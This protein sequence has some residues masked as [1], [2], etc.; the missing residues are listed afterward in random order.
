MPLLFII[1]INNFSR[2]SDLLFTILFADDTSVFIEGTSY[3]KVIDVL[4]Q[5][6]KRV[7][8]WLKANTL[9]INTQKKPH[10][11]M[12]HRTRIKDDCQPI[13]IDGNPI[14]YTKN[15][16]FLGVI[17]DQKLNWSDHILY[18]KNEISK[19]IGIINKTRNLLDKNTVRNLYF[20]FI[21]PYLIYCIEIWG[22]TNGRHLNSIIKI[23]KKGI[24]AISFAHYL[25]ETSPLFKRLKNFLT[26]KKFVIKR[27]ALL[28]F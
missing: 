19:S 23:N 15:T 11:M 27:I 28:M 17:I 2:A 16:T 20:T 6:L 18:I 12:F 13:V 21:Y 7:D 22:N 1:Y 26:L 3:N 5:E 4:N 25:D 9:T 24:R 8:L 10:Y 14:M